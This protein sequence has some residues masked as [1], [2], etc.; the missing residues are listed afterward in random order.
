MGT[1]GLKNKKP[2]MSV[3]G[4]AEDWPEEKSVS[5]S[6]LLISYSPSQFIPTD[7]LFFLLRCT[8]LKRIFN[9]F[10]SSFSQHLGV[11]D[12]KTEGQRSFFFL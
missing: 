3:T 5:P 12:L 1:V 10:S 2:N 7:R 9:C 8:G 6:D 4:Y 11:K